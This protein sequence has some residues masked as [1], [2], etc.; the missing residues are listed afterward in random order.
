MI[1]IVMYILHKL[2]WGDKFQTSFRFQR[3]I[4]EISISVWFHLKNVE[5][6]TTGVLPVYLSMSI[7]FVTVEYASRSNDNFNV[8]IF[9]RASSFFC[10]N[11]AFK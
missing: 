11:F 9:I 7:A 1:L 4:N 2:E 3:R 8:P 6:K 10:L 5:R